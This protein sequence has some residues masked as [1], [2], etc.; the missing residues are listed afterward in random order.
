VITN[1]TPV[2][3]EH[4]VVPLPAEGRWREIVNTDAKNYGGSGKGNAGEVT[5]HREPSGRI[6]AACILPPLATIWL[7]LAD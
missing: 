1:F 6:A 5:A 2:P 4:Y 3:R 7:E